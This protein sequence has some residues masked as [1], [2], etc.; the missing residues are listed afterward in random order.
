VVV[1]L[2]GALAGVV[3]PVL[4][5]A[6][7]DIS[8][9][10]VLVWAS[11]DGGQVADRSYALPE[12]IE[13]QRSAEIG[14]PEEFLT[15]SA[16]LRRSAK[17]GVH[18]TTV[19]IE[20]ARSRDVV[21]TNMRARILSREPNISGTLFCIRPQGDISA[22][23]VGFD[24]DEFRPSARVLDGRQ[25]GGS[26]FADRA[27]QLAD[28]ETVVFQVE[29]RAAKGHYRW[30]IDVDMVIDGKAQTYTAKPADGEFEISGLSPQYGSVF[31]WS[32]NDAWKFLDVREN[33]TGY[34]G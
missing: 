22:D 27:V 6:V 19:T 16:A 20:G 28:G 15:D 11:S 9:P 2:V 7:R 8:R 10:P 4:W 12:V 21:I 14:T 34:C 3:A 32:G 30:V 31:N 24:L 25:L 26:Y 18:G 33:P 1:A 29:S 13:P 5:N 23:R 17:V